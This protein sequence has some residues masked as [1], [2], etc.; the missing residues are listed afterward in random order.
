MANI[1]LT[2]NGSLFAKLGHHAGVV[3]DIL[4]SQGAVTNGPDYSVT[5]PTKINTI[6]TDYQIGVPEQ[7]IVDGIYSQLTSFQSVPSLVTYLASTL[8]PNT[9]I[10]LANTSQALSTKTVANALTVLVNQMVAT[11]NT[12]QASNISVGAQTAVGTP[13]GNPVFVLGY[14]RGDGRQQDYLF[15]ET[16]TYKVTSDSQSGGATLNQEPVQITGQNAASSPLAYNYPLGSGVNQSI[17]LIDASQNMSGGTLLQNGDFETFTNSNIPDNWVKVTGTIGTQILQGNVAYTGNSSLE[18]VG[19]GA[20][21]TTVTQTFNT[22]PSTTLGAGGTA[23]KLLPQINYPINLWLRQTSVPAA[24]VI[25]VSFVNGSN[26]IIQDSQGNNCATNTNLNTSSA[27]TWI[28]MQGMFRLPAALP[29]SVALRLKL[30]TALSSGTDLY[31]DRIAVGGVTGS[32]GATQL[33]SGGPSI[34]GF[35]G[36][37]KVLV[38]DSWTQALTSNAGLLGQYCDRALGLKGQNVLIPS[39]VSP[40]ISDSVVS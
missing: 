35:S 40:T 21:A 34:A 3:N 16:L 25:E 24:G 5:I 39:A 18:F 22:T 7:N 27:N 13:N 8:T 2:G 37:T 36:N 10:D 4:K 15:A 32:S 28:N 19:D 12:I 11:S 9:L 23:A 26:V 17:N 14:L 29:S 20:T 38:Q 1:I 6:E 33:Y 30:T 31:I